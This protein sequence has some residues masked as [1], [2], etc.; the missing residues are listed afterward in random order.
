MQLC[1]R[2]VKVVEMATHNCT[3]DPASTSVMIDRAVLPRIGS[4]TPSTR[5]KASSA[6]VDDHSP[7][8]ECPYCSQAGF[9]DAVSV[10]RHVAG[11]CRIAQS[12]SSSQSVSNQ[13]GEGEAPRS[14]S[15]TA[16]SSM[17][18]IEQVAVREL[19]QGRLRRKND[20][21]RIV[22]TRFPP[23]TGNNQTA[24]DASG[25]SIK[26]G[27]RKSTPTSASAAKS[28]GRAPITANKAPIQT[29]AP[30]R[31]ALDEALGVRS[32]SCVLSVPV[33]AAKRQAR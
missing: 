9:K 19:L 13:Q 32:S 11:E 25:R 21:D 24:S 33:V 22:R 14:P 15:R 29:R 23:I 10:E 8:F 17:G 4:R 31:D 27:T 26:S 12:F 1:Q 2:F 18:T 7:S 16:V 6:V 20:A 3:G 28:A 30:T 5:D